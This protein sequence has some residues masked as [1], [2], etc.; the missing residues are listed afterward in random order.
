MVA[1]RSV[2][3]QIR[4]CAARTTVIFVA[5]RDW[6][7]DIGFAAADLGAAVEP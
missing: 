6:H 3:R 2:K 1:F 7:I 5:R 4:L